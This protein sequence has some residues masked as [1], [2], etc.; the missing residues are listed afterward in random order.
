MNYIYYRSVPK[1]DKGGGVK[2]FPYFADVICAWSLG[3]LDLKPNS[4]CGSN[5]SECGP[6][7]ERDDMT[8][9]TGRGIW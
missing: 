9:H 7:S 1:A 6:E 5:E 4:P 3:V 8:I 2:K